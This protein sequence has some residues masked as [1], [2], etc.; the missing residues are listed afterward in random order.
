MTAAEVW[1]VFFYGSTFPRYSAHAVL[2]PPVL[3]LPAKPFR[4]H[5]VMSRDA[6]C[7]QTTGGAASG[8]AGARDNG[9]MKV[10]LCRAAQAGVYALPNM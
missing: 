10:L 8:M 7:G 1:S 6:A 5:A 3:D 4:P 2:L 9:E